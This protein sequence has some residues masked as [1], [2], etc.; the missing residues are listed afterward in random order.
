MTARSLFVAVSVALAAAGCCVAGTD[1]AHPRSF[2]DEARAVAPLS[3]DG[4]VICTSFHV[5]QRVWITAGHCAT[6][7]GEYEIDGEPAIVLDLSNDPDG[8][9]AIMLGPARSA[10]VPLGL[11]PAFGTRVHFIGY[12]QHMRIHR[13]VIEGVVGDTE[14]TE[15]ETTMEVDGG[16][17]GSPVFDAAGRV[18]GIVVSSYRRTPYSYATR[19]SL[20]RARLTQRLLGFRGL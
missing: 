6:G 16:A 14:G 7:S 20:V 3:L 12:P 18:V 1:V 11:D 2:Q 17:S 4:E 15:F 5:G 13:V 10:Y 9:L 19:V 8:D